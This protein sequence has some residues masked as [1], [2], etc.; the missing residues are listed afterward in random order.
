MLRRHARAPSRGDDWGCCPSKEKSTEHQRE[1]EA[2][3]HHK[4]SQA[5]NEDHDV[6]YSNVAPAWSDDKSDNSSNPI[7]AVAGLD[8]AGRATDTCNRAPVYAAA[9]S[10]LTV[11]TAA[12]IVA[13]VAVL[14]RRRRCLQQSG[15]GASSANKKL[16]GIIAPAAHRN[17]LRPQPAQKSESSRNAASSTVSSASPWKRTTTTANSN[18]H[19]GYIPLPGAVYPTAGASRRRDPNPYGLPASQ[20]SYQPHRVKFVTLQRKRTVDSL[21][22]DDVDAAADD[23]DLDVEEVSS[24]VG[25]DSEV[26]DLQALLPLASLRSLFGVVSGVFGLPPAVGRAQPTPAC[27]VERGAGGTAAACGTPPCAIPPASSPQVAGGRIDV[28]HSNNPAVL[29]PSDVSRDMGTNVSAEPPPP[30][31]ATPPVQS[32]P[33]DFE[34]VTSADAVDHVHAAASTATLASSP[35]THSAVTSDLDPAGSDDAVSPSTQSLQRQ[36]ITAA[37]SVASTRRQSAQSTGSSTT[38]DIASRQTTLER[39]GGLADAIGLGDLVRSVTG[40]QPAEVDKVEPF[41]V[42]PD[43]GLQIQKRRAQSLQSSLP[44]SHFDMPN[45]N[46]KNGNVQ[47]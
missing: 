35:A 27:A 2:S 3:V 8:A 24:P 9:A 13:L 28:T 7:T 46:A 12:L 31:A 40:S 38:H 17:L 32:S 23:A 29:Q 30:A 44:L 34:S 43:L 6:L 33:N 1:N 14:V 4:D 22:G 37:D 16:V 41:W 11:V 20:C 25:L 42:P 19:H 36:S 45:A 10:V 47:T 15:A 21:T 5:A 18:Q 26:P 39:I